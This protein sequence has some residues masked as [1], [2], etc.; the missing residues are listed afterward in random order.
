MKIVAGLTI[1]IATLASSNVLAQQ[2]FNSK[3][4]FIQEWTQ[5][6]NGKKLVE[7]VS[8][9]SSGYNG[10][11]VSA[12]SVNSM[13]LCSNNQLI[14]TSQSRVSSDGSGMYGSD[15]GTEKVIAQ[16]RIVDADAHNAIMEITAKNGVKGLTRLQLANGRLYVNRSRV[17]GGQSEFCQ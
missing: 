4:S 15:G 3:A 9:S 12:A 11:S 1:A 17:S 13:H 8:H 16:W 6:L 7:S 14:Y 5:A 2:P 10:I